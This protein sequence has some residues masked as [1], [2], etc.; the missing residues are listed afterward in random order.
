[1]CARH[2]C[3]WCVCVHSKKERLIHRSRADPSLSPGVE[4]PQ[5]RQGLLLLGG[6]LSGSC[7]CNGVSAAR[8]VVEGMCAG[9][10]PSPGKSGQGEVW[11]ED[12]G[13]SSH[14]PAE[15]TFL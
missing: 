15:A 6:G 9:E 13:G 7:C 14:L 10:T 3:V 12:G 1:M 4:L 11:R 5:P 8:L 2:V